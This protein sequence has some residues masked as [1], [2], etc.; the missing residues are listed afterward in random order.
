MAGTFLLK[1]QA[2]KAA[3]WSYLAELAARGIPPAIF[4]VLARILTPTDFGTIAV[5]MIVVSFS[6]TIWE[7]G[8]STSLIRGNENT[9]EIASIVFWTNL[10]LSVIL[11]TSIFVLADQIFATLNTPDATLVFPILGVQIIL[12]SLCSVPIALFQKDLDFKALFWTRLLAAV[13]Q[14]CVSIPVA[15]SGH[16]Y[17]AIVAGSITATIVQL[18]VL[19]SRTPWRPKIDYNL[20]VF[21]NITRFSVWSSA[22]GII[23]WLYLWIEIIILA[24]IL[25]TAVVGLYRTGNILINMIYGIALSPLMPVAFSTFSRIQSNR[26]HLIGILRSNNKIM[27]YVAIAIATGVSFTSDKIGV[28]IFNDRWQGINFV[29]GILA[30]N[31][32]FNWI[33][34]PNVVALR[35]L[36]RP[37]VATKIMLLT[38]ILIVPAFAIAANHGLKVFLLIRLGLTMFVVFPVNFYVSGKLIGLSIR[39]FAADLRKAVV[40]S[41]LMLAGLYCVNILT[42]KFLST[43]H[44]LASDIVV[45]SIIFVLCVLLLDREFIVKQISDWRHYRS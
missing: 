37:D 27:L 9:E 25:D 5:V 4:L 17:W 28:T 35:A 8:F 12:S 1:G 26:D 42:S 45:G 38:L 30:I 7:H 14:G 13:S 16:G 22:E 21:K 18:I 20:R 36:G 10:L 23:A 24:T 11:Y 33:Q 15:L 41:V 2:L 34:A 19:W 3:K 6:Q 29:I 44:N 39:D 32:A 43:W 40:T 31:F